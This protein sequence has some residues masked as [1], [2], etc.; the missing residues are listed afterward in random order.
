MATYLEIVYLVRTQIFLT[1]FGTLVN[2]IQISCA[3]VNLSIR[4][5]IYRYCLVYSLLFQELI[6][7]EFC[8]IVFLVT[9]KLFVFWM[10]VQVSSKASVIPETFSR[11]DYSYPCN[12]GPNV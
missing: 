6:L 11:F 2:F 10:A 1:I 4:Q 9:L 8:M 5:Q 7:V 3:L 12:F